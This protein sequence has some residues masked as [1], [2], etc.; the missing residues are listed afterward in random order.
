MCSRGSKRNGR[1]TTLHQTAREVIDDDAETTRDSG[2]RGD[3]ID[4]I[5]DQSLEIRD[6]AHRPANAARQLLELTSMIE[7]EHIELAARAACCR[8]S[9]QV[10][11]AIVEIGAQRRCIARQVLVEL[12]ERRQRRRAPVARDHERTTGIAKLAT[13]LPRGSGEKSAQQSGEKRIARTQCI[14]HF[15][16]KSGHLERGSTGPGTKRRLA[17]VGRRNDG[18]AS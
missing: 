1:G 13:T 5:A 11:D 7:R 10:I 12:H 18:A 8:C 9:V 14:E 2:R 17:R 15:D 3:D 16:R 4:S 6:A